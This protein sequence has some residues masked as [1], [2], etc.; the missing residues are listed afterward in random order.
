MTDT[1]ILED[2]IMR[3]F[4]IHHDKSVEWKPGYFILPCTLHDNLCRFEL[5]SAELCPDVHLLPYNFD[6]PEEKGCQNG[7]CHI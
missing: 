1:E 2:D 6:L 3:R 7:K 5:A 4:C